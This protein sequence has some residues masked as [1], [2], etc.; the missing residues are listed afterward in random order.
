LRRLLLLRLRG[1]SHFHL[2]GKKALAA[3]Q[4]RH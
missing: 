4:K 1:G 3:Q 2:G